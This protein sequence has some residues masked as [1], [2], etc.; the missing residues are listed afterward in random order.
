MNA[1]NTPAP[2]PAAPAAEPL[3]E[4]REA[5]LWAFLD[6]ARPRFEALNA[7]IPANVRLSVGHMS[8]GYRS[9]ALGE[10]Y[11]PAMSA[12]GHYEIFI[13]P[14][15]ESAARIADVLTHELIHTVCWNDGHG[16]E[17]GR[18][19]RGLGLVGPLTA[20]SAGQDWFAWAAPILEALGPLPYS[21]MLD[22]AGRAPSPEPR[23]APTPG[24]PATGAP[25]TGGFRPGFKKKPTFA[26]KVYCPDCGWTAR[27]SA[28]HIDRHSHLTCPVPDCGGVMIAEARKD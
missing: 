8:T 1:L 10:T 2:A 28:V 4:T 11:S 21:P 5:W 12:D 22:M 3:F 19:A 18:I 27:V 23:P 20:T 25:A 17:F 26:R 16:K 15:N 6:A 13:S 24:A 9:R 7:P 14:K